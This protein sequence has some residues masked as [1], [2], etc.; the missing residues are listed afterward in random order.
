MNAQRIEKMKRG[1]LLVNGLAGRWWT[2]KRSYAL[3][4]K[5]IRA[6]LDVTDP[7]PLPPDHPL[8]KAPNL[9]LTPH[10][11]GDSE[12]FMARAFR[13]VWEQVERFA[14]GEPLLNIVGG[15]Y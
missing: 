12:K 10:V 13:L 9:L 2:R 14:R 5:K 8:W 15:E 11:G 4:A 3:Q 7:K 6:A 1:A